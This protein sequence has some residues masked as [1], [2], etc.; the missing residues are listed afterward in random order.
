VGF[1]TETRLFTSNVIE[2]DGYKFC[3]QWPKSTMKQI[4]GRQP[5][6]TSLINRACRHQLPNSWRPRTF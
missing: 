2:L 5:R 4:I 6:C 3:K 1:T